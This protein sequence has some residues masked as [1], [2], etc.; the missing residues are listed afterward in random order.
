[1]PVALKKLADQVIVITGA[2]SGIGLVLARRAAAGGAKLV[3]NAR[4]EG[5]LQQLVSQITDA[6]GRAVYVAGDVAQIDDMRRLANEAIVSFGGFDTWVN[7]AGV[8]IYGRVLDVPLEDHRRLFETNYWGLVHGSLVAVEHLRTKG[9][10]LIQVGSALSDR[11]IPL[12]GTYCASKHA[13][14]AYTEALRMELERE[15]APISISLIKPASIDTPYRAHAR[16]LLG[17]VPLNPP[18]VYAPDVVAEAILHCAQ[19]AERDVFVGAGGKFLSA[20]AY[21]APRLTD[22]LMEATLFDVQQSDEPVPAGRQDSLHE[23]SVDGAERGGYP[24]YV[25]ESSLY[26]RGALNGLWTGMAIVGVGLVTSLVLRG[27]GSARV[28]AARR[29]H[30]TPASKLTQATRNMIHARGH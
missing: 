4:N 21:Y 5:A 7:N 27:L 16:N 20:A 10:A 30:E 19:M 12:Q 9:G 13:V 8:S 23:A 14:K 29:S 11:A 18:P 15:R 6:G 24:G 2:T 22:R 1:V 17:V 26:T 25:A 28:S 3:L